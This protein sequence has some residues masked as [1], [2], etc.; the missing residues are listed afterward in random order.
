MAETTMLDPH[1]LPAK[2]LKLLTDADLRARELERVTKNITIGRNGPGPIRIYGGIEDP[3]QSGLMQALRYLTLCVAGPVRPHS[4]NGAYSYSVKHRAEE[5]TING[6]RCYVS[7]GAMIVATLMCGGDIKPVQD[8]NAYLG[9]IQPRRCG[10]LCYTGCGR[11]ITH[12]RKQ[13]C[14]ACRAAGYSSR[15]SRFNDFGDFRGVL[16]NIPDSF[17]PTT[18]ILGPPGGG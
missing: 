3:G 16:A 12:S 7:N 10:H 15:W 4:R 1:A 18:D 14:S 5:L 9:I 17:P 8:V 13:T 11:L 2:A 6:M